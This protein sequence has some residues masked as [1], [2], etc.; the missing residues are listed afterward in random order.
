MYNKLNPFIKEI[1]NAMKILYT[2]TSIG[3]QMIEDL[4]A[5]GQPIQIRTPYSNEPQGSHY[6][7]KSNTV[8][9][10]L[11]NIDRSFTINEKYEETPKWL[12]I[13]HEFAHS[14]SRLIL[15]SKLPKGV[16]VPSSEFNGPRDVGWDEIVATHIENIMRTEKSLPLWSNYSSR[17]SEE[18]YTVPNS[19]SSLLYKEVGKYKSRFYDQDGKVHFKG[20]KRDNKTG[21]TYEKQ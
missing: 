21:Y 9:I 15:K 4:N 6:N 14:Y 10:N 12:V 1:E 11:N 17:E 5:L 13:G 19:A 2:E 16:W 8:V 18:D 7:F 3:K 20:I